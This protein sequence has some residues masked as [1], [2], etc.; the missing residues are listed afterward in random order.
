MKNKRK[1]PKHTENG[2]AQCGDGV[3]G[4]RPP[5][6]IERRKGFG[7]PGLV[8]IGIRESEATTDQSLA[9]KGPIKPPSYWKSSSLGNDSFLLFFF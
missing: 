4:A 9:E 8:S 5:R 3:C 6:R 1:R 7:V 2:P